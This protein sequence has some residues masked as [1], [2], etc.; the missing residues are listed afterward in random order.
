MDE[1]FQ[2]ME[3]KDLLSKHQKDV[4]AHKLLV[5]KKQTESK[6]KE[7]LTKE[8]PTVKDYQHLLQWKLGD[9]YV[10]ITKGMRAAQLK[11][12]WE[13]LKDTVTPDVIVPEEPREPEVPSVNQTQLGRTTKRKF[14]E[15]IASGDVL[16]ESEIREIIA[17]LTAVA[18]EKGLQMTAV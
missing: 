7:L 17:K 13:R 5:S 9:D 16:G 8:K 15:T 2:A 11:E 10:R 4:A 1:M 18:A 12:Q 3:Y 6:A 14:D